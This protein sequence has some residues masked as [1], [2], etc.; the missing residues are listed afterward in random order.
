M[1]AKL[2]RREVTKE[3]GKGSGRVVYVATIDELIEHLVQLKAK[4]GSKALEVF[5]VSPERANAEGRVSPA[6]RVCAG[7]WECYTI[8]I[9]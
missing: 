8:S 6:S 7:G 2:G 1:R 3:S 9:L 5:D 4:H